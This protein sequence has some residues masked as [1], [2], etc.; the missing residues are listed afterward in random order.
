VVAA[1]CDRRKRRSQSAATIKL[2]HY[3][4]SRESVGP[5]AYPCPSVFI[6]QV[7][8]PVGHFFVEAI[9]KRPQS[10]DFDD[11]PQS[12]AIRGCRRSLHFAQHCIHKGLIALRSDQLVMTLGRSSV[13]KDIFNC[14]VTAKARR[15]VRCFVADFSVFSWDKPVGG[16]AAIY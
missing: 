7:S 14:M 12:L 5:R 16:Q 3:R 2:Y 6:G 13:V 11:K 4:N 8:S 15:T 10:E 9:M 1:V